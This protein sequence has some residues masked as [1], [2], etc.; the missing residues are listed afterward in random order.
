MKHD[1][2]RPPCAGK[3]YLFESPYLVD[4]R[5][6]VKFCEVCPARLVVA[7]RRLADDQVNHDGTWAG[8]LYVNGAPHPRGKRRWTRADEV[9]S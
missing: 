3:G 9:A 4:Y 8:V 7:C 6:A 1:E 5:Q 2:V